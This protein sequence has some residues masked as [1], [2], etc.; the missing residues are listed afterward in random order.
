[1]IKTKVDDWIED[2]EEIMNEAIVVPGSILT[3]NEL[4]DDLEERLL[5]NMRETAKVIRL[6]Q[7]VNHRTPGLREVLLR[8]MKEL[9]NMMQ[10]IDDLKQ[11][12]CD[13]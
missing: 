6:E 13:T 7:K 1:M 8:Q 12:Y 2:R 3:K 4:A 11:K 5:F 10:M 9:E